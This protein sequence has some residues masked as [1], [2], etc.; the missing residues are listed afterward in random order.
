MISRV[1]V[2]KEKMLKIALIIANLLWKC[3]Q[4]YGTIRCIFWVFYR[5][6]VKNGL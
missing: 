5:F 2:F 4:K 3:N 6:R 1:V